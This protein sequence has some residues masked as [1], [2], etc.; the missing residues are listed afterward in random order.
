[1]LSVN[2]SA[3]E[4]ADPG[5]GAAVADMLAA[6]KFDPTRLVLEVTESAMMKDTDVVVQNL[7]ALRALGLRIAV[8]DFGTGYSSL[9]YLEQFPV[10]ILKIDRSFVT[11]LGD[12]DSAGLAQAI[13]QIAET[14]GHMTIA[15]GV[16]N[17]EQA[18]RLHA[19]GCHL[20]Q[21]YYLGKPLDA[22]ATE[23]LLRE[24]VREL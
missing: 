1:M 18:D 15:E 6:S 3:R 21:G 11:A 7:H 24:K 2:L 23:Q 9:A 12:D 10:D 13:I 17:P 16:E 5:T 19:L 8:D 22:N 14:L 20:A 4:L